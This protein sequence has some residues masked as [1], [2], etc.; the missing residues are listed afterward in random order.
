ME[1]I[2][3]S[4][5]ENIKNMKENLDEL[6]KELLLTHSTIY[7]WNKPDPYMTFISISGDYSWNDLS[8]EGK[9]I[10]SKIKESYLIFSSIMKALLKNQPLKNIESFKKADDIL[11]ACIEQNDS[12]WYENTSIAYSKVKNALEIMINIID[13]IYSHGN[14]YLLIPD[15]NALLYNKDIEIWKF[16]GIDKFCLILTPTILS[17]LDS[18]KVNH[19]NELT[20]EN[21]KKLINKIKEYR[22]R[23]RLSDGVPIVK[24]KIELK[25]IAVEPNL[26][27]TLPWL[28]PNNGDDRIITSVLDIMRLNIKSIV[29]LITNDINLQNKADYA[30]I[31]Y[32]E[33]PDLI[34]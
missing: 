28:D 13:N 9:Q 16:K 12:T 3:S 31:P 5:V 22:R 7:L 29:I 19:R 23:G 18:L 27:E 21:A 33:P 30:R 11:K 24:G 1:A 10:Q 14:S 8:I 2:K 25:S 17:E 26:S 4:V 32:L 34:K 15:T 6:F 20:R